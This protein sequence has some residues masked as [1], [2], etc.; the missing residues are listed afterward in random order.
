MIVEQEVIKVVPAQPQVIYVPTYNP[1]VV[2]VQPSGPS[3][4]TAVAAAAISFGVGLAIG[5]WL[6]N[7]CNWHTHSVYYHGWHGVGWVRNPS[8]TSTSSVS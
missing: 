6:N 3:T 7:D 8:V 4:G 5:A 1:Q 2:Y